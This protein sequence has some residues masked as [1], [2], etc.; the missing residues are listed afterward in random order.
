MIRILYLLVI[1]LAT[2][3]ADAQSVQTPDADDS[4]E[5]ELKSFEMSEGYE[6]NL[7]ADESN[8]I[9]NPIAIA[10]FMRDAAFQVSLA[11]RPRGPRFF[12]T[13]HVSF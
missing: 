11:A 1:F 13:Q 9:A 2:S 12:S 4:V 3:V 10:D 8:G 6:T 7:F 5:A